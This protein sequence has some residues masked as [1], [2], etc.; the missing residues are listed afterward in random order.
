M[1]PTCVIKASADA[2]EVRLPLGALGYEPS[3][4]M[5]T[6][7]DSIGPSTSPFQKIPTPTLGFGAK[8]QVLAGSLPQ[9]SP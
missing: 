7:C 1:E 6:H 4:A 5:L 3:R 8:L 9:L 2:F